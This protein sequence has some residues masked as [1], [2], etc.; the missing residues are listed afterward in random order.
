L[1]ALT[2]IGF[3]FVMAEFNPFNWGKSV[4]GGMVIA[5][6]SILILSVPISQL[7]KMEFDD[8]KRIL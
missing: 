5:M 7:I 8:W 3:S 6:G 2:Y 1:W 4:I